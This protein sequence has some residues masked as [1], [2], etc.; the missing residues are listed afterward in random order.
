M[1]ENKSSF[2]EH[3][4]TDRILGLLITLCGLAATYYFIIHQA[5]AAMRH[6]SGVFLSVKGVMLS[7]VGIAIGVV[8]TAFGSRVTEFLGDNTKR[9]TRTTWILIVSFCAA[10]SLLYWWLKGFIEGYGYVFSY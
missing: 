3:L 8:Y 10:D 2:T 9:P 1:P 5:I 6:D 4:D 7:P